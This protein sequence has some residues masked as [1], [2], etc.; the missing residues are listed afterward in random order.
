MAAVAYLNTYL[1][2]TL[3]FPSGESL[4]HFKSPSQDLFM[5]CSAVPQIILFTILLINLK[6]LRSREVATSHT[7]KETV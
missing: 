4:I 6:A 3:M 1:P 2:V 5:I 7:L